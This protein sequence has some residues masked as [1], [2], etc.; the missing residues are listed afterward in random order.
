MLD[1]T[2]VINGSYGEVWHEGRWLTNMYGM[3]AEVDL[4][5]EEIKVSGARWTH[6][7][8][9]G[10]SG[11]GSISG[12][13]ITSEL[14]RMIQSVT[15]NRGIEFKTELIS[16]LDDPEAFGAER[17]RL[18]GVSFDN[19]PLVGWEVGSIVEEE[20]NFTF[21]GFE[22]LDIITAG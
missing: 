13:K 1:S 15:A 5:K 14:V 10:V 20:W 16:K 18:K 4:S 17:V 11:S 3:T 22:L 12:Y 2:R 19:I 21:E 6:H 7:K 8:V 9:T